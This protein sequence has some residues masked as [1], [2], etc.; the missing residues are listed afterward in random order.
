MRTKAENKASNHR[1]PRTTALVLHCGHLIRYDL[2][3]ASCWCY[4]RD[5][6][7]SVL[8]AVRSVVSGDLVQLE[9]GV[10]ALHGPRR[11][12]AGPKEE[13]AHMCAE[14]VAVS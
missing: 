10:D 13:L 11:H 6:G 9:R 8:G 5:E 4:R 12:P 7:S 14:N 2:L 3:L 1:V